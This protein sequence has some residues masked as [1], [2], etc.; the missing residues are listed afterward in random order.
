MPLYLFS[1]PKCSFRF[2]RLVPV[3]CESHPCPDCAEPAPRTVKGQTFSHAFEEPATPT[4]SGV[5]SYDNPSADMAVGRDAAKKWEEYEGRKK[6]KEKI[7]RESG[8]HALSWASPGQDG[9]VPMS[10][11]A[12]KKRV[13]TGKE[14]FRRAAE[15]KEKEGR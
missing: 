7:R 15:Q 6:V 13:E 12:Y 3:S 10:P 5:H 11:D 14:L 9:Y 8:T 4:N 1:C 2:E